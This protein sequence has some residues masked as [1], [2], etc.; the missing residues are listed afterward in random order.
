MSDNAAGFTGG[1]PQHYD[2]GLGPMIFVDYAADIARRAAAYHPARV[3]ETAAGTGIVTRALRDHLPV[4]AH[5]TATDLNPPML[6][7]AR[8]KFRP[9][10]QI[11]FQP[12]DATALPF[13]DGSFD[14]VVCQFGVM[15]FPDKDKS[16]SEVYRVLAPGGHYL[17]STWDSHR[18]NPFGRIAHAVAGRFFPADPPQFYNVP[19]SCHQI[20]PIKASLTAA[21]FTDVDVDVVKLEKQIPDVAVF[22]R[23]AVYGNPLIDQIR[24]RGGVE[25]EQI[26]DAMLQE[27]RR[28]FGPGPGRMPLQA[29]VFSAKKPS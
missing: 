14:A 5:M 26:V 9:S 10:E 1:I 20:D 2:Q 7:I 6:D 11:A 27:F 15:F 19:F 4:A 18:H 17:F 22:A 12:A 21:G 25:P 16:Y 28:E 23:A 8:T 3:L 24:A 29:I 13:A